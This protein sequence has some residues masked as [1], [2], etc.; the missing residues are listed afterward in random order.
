MYIVVL[1]SR[2]G[3]Y[4]LAS[5]TNTFSKNISDSV[6]FTERN[7]AAKYATLAESILNE[8]VGEDAFVGREMRVEILEVIV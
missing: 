4:Y 1:E 2:Y 3:L 5:L 7:R 6:I 8:T